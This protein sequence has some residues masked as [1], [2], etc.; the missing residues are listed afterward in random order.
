MT[1][2]AGYFVVVFCCFAA[3]VNVV[4]KRCQK[5]LRDREGRESGTGERKE[6]VVGIPTSLYP[7]IDA[8]FSCATKPNEQKEYRGRGTLLLTFVKDL[9]HI[10]WPHLSKVSKG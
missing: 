2:R 7:N 8:W 10:Q 9:F 4:K 1:S 5:W 6:T 3:S